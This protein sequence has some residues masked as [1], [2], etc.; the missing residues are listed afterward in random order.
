MSDLICN[1]PSN[2]VYV[3]REFLLDGQEGHGEFVEGI[4]VTA[5]SIPGRAFYFE[6]YLP[7]YGALFDKLPISAFV[8]S[9]ELPEDDLPLPDLQFWN[10]MDYGITCITKQFIGSMDYEIFTRS[11]KHLHGTYLFT[12]DNYHTHNDEIDYSTS[13]V[14]EEHKSFNCLELE[15]GQY[16][17]YPNNRMRVYD[18]SLT[19]PEPKQPDFKVSTEYYQVENGYQYRLGDTDEYFWIDPSKA[20][21][22]CNDITVSVDAEK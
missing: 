10:C 9:P 15:N 6:T 1:L 16:C 14:P 2:K 19:P 13:E 4:W 11:H 12:L 21:K 20:V 5:K 3:R 18:N 8:S 7:E 22:N 17:L